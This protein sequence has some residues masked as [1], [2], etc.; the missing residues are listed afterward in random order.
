[1]EIKD[2]LTFTGLWRLH[3]VFAIIL[4]TAIIFGM[5]EEYILKKQIRQFLYAIFLIVLLFIP[6]IFPSCVFAIE[7][8][9]ANKNAD[10]VMSM[11]DCID[12]ALKNDPHIKIYANTQKIQKSG[13]G[14]EKSNYFPTLNGGTGYYLNNSNYSG[15]Y[16][17]VQ[18]NNYYGLNLGVNQF[19]WDF[20]KTTARISMAKYNYQAAGYDLDNAILATIYNVKIAY[21]TVLAARANEDIYARSVRINEL[22]YERTKTMYDV[23]LKSK[24]DVVNAEVYL[25]DAK[26]SHLQAQNTYKTA[27]INLNNS[28]YYTNAPEYSIKDTETFNF[29]KNYSIKNEINVAYDRKNYDANGADAQIKDGAILTSGIEKRDILKTYSFKPFDLSMEEAIKKAYENRPDIKSLELVKRASEESLKAI[30]RSYMPKINA[31]AGYGMQNGSERSSNGLNAYA[32]VDIPIV[33]AMSIKCQ[34]DQG[35]AYLDTAVINIDLLKKNVYFGVQNYYVN[36][37]QLEKRIPLMSAK[38]TQ[39]LENFELA[40]GRYAV[41]LGNFLELQEAQTNYNNAQL[42]F[43]Q[44]VFD[45]NEARYYLE[46]TMGLK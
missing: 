2:S 20:G 25:T 44:S 21:A 19:I 4:D 24:I 11:E 18:N 28:M 33:N 1:M 39:T 43:V 6:L 17:N 16:N 9:T 45:Y 8:T 31:S 14:I 3:K 34:I 12:Y 22:N 15:N 37:K 32:G 38:V 7:N 35:K 40:D 5:D 30:K 42:A 41:G 29:Q 27:L 36:M 13:V 10:M 23:G 46:K 26:I